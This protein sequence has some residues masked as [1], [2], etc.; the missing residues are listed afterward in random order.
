M[1]CAL[2]APVALDLASPEFQKRVNALRH[3]DNVTNWFYLL[4]EYVALGLIVG[5]TISFYWNREAW[6]WAWIWNVP[7]TFL[8]MVCI[9]ACQH[10]LTNVGHEASHYILFRN[11][12][13]N[14]LASDWFAMFPMLSCTHHYRLQHLAHHQYVNDAER[15]PDVVQ[16][17]ESGHRFNFPMT[18][19][20]FVWHCVIK[21]VLWFPKLIR[22]VRV[23]AKYSSTGGGKGPYFR[24]GSEPKMLVI[25]G[26][27]Y[28][29]AMIATLAL[30][31]NLGNPWLLA[32]VPTALAIVMVIVYAVAPDR[33]YLRTLVKSDVPA[34]WMTIM[35]LS[36]LTVLFSTL[37]WL[38]YVTD[39]PWLLWY[40]VVWI[41][42]LFTS[43][44][45]FM[46]LRQ[47]VQHGNA[48]QG[49]LTNTRVF[50]VNRLIRLAVFPLG[51][52]WHLPHHL[53]P[54]VPHYRLKQLHELLMETDEYRNHAIIV[55][56]YFFHC[57]NPPEKPTVVELMAR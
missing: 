19:Q 13:L 41:I 14:E 24:H 4:R 8:A 9:G 47:I 1:S 35:R 33:L 18:P 44:S 38:T 22:Y 7:I 3:T 42:P 32:L 12:L 48:D 56:G 16:M 31:V 34:R 10:R 54:L 39:K 21:Q 45:F 46:L 43:F 2:P 15:D 36:H 51:M 26:V 30:L 49:R 27:S 55:E 40:F 52:D 29:L 5:G 53:F 6:G 57:T 37:A 11:R 50:C 28:A 20:Q 25:F 17:S 23:R